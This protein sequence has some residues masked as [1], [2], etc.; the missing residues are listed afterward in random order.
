[1][2]LAELFLII[3]ARSREKTMR[4][5]RHKDR[6]GKATHRDTEIGS[7]DEEAAMYRHL[8]E[9]MDDGALLIDVE[10]GEILSANLSAQSLWLRHVDELRGLRVSSLFRLGD[11]GLG[12]QLAASLVSSNQEILDRV[13]LHRADGS[14]LPAEMRITTHVHDGRRLALIV[15][16]DISERLRDARH[17]EN[18]RSRLI[19]LMT[20]VEDLV[21]WFD[22][23]GR[24]LGCNPAVERHLG[25]KAEALRGSR[26]ADLTPPRHPD[27]FE[28]LTKKTQD[29][30][31]PPELH[32]VN[33]AGGI[34]ELEVKSS[35]LSFAGPEVWL[36]VGRD[37]TER[38]RAARALQE[39]RERLEDLVRRKSR[40]LADTSAR[41]E[42][43][44]RERSHAE[45]EAGSAM[46]IKKQFLTNVNHEFRT[47]LNSV[48][49][50]LSLLRDTPLDPK[51]REFL[52]LI[53][54]GASR[55]R[56]LLE[57]LLE[58]SRLERGELML[59][60]SPLSLHALLSGLE[61]TYQS[62]AEEKGLTFSMTVPDAVP[63]SLLG[64]GR[65]LRQILA[66]LLSNAVEFTDEGSVLLEAQLLGVTP[67]KVTLRFDVSDTG[68]GI[69]PGQLGRLFD[70]L[71]QLDESRTRAHGGIGIGL[72][73]VRRLARLMGGDIEVTGKDG[74]GAVFGFT[75]HLERLSSPA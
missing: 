13:E 40:Q 38:N 37:V 56:V 15:T 39:S 8:F 20:Q 74:S 71:T 59:A 24:I 53:E 5:A 45:D 42:A 11:N 14:V 31:A 69:D 50:G 7:H 18:S 21:F 33:A 64:D 28:L 32:L 10:S 72:A 54:D 4:I 75:V 47:P 67:R 68:R 58:L 46:R 52:G 43:E 62:L 26:F 57:D 44:A 34:V 35:K 29:S 17:Y 12:D 48:I 73:L 51:Q 27:P 1:M 25:R 9:T 6:E 61:K 36:A 30:K 65:R 60:R 23:T 41:L 63:D 2:F 16:R 22:D 55:L 3:E 70:E 66:H 49:G 19:T